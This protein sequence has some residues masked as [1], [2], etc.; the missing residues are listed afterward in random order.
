MLENVLGFILILCLIQSLKQSY[1]LS[2]VVIPTFMEK[3]EIL[4]WSTQPVR[5]EFIFEYKSNGFQNI[6]SFC[7]SMG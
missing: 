5:T 2:H 7:Y 3:T 6:C 1:V 4:P